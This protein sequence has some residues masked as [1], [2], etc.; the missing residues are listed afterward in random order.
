MLKI[1]V[2]LSLSLLTS[3]FLFSLARLS[4]LNSHN[5]RIWD[6]G[7]VKRVGERTKFPHSNTNPLQRKSTYTS[8]LQP[9]PKIS[10]FFP[11]KKRKYCSCTSLSHL[12]SSRVWP[13]YKGF[14][15]L[16]LDH[17]MKFEIGFDVLDS[18]LVHT[19]LLLGPA[20][21]AK[22]LR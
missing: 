8:A 10:S 15:K 2:S 6:N 21:L 18:T 1:L 12:V 14:R 9:R 17:E 13:Q 19:V 20:L 22:I 16:I 3:Q 4:S 11:L 5:L 7:S